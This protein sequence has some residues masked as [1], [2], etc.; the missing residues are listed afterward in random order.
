MSIK[1]NIWKLMVLN[2][3]SWFLLFMPTV[4]LFFQENGLSMFQVILLQSFFAIGV[5]TLEIPSGYFADIYGRKKSVIVGSILSCLGFIGFSLSYNFIG[6]VIAELLLAF[7]VSFLSGADYALMY[8]SLVILKQESKYKILQGRL[9]SV[10]N[11]SESIAALVGGLIAVYGLRYTF[12]AETLITFLA[13]PLAFTLKEP[14]RHIMDL[15]SGH[16]KSLLR[17]V[18][19]ALHDHKEIKWLILYSAL[20]GAMGF[21]MVWFIQPYFNL[22]ELPLK[23]FGIAWAILNFSVGI[24]T[25]FAHNFEETLGKTKSIISLLILLFIAYLLLWWFSSIWAI[26]FILIFYLV[27]GI[28]GPIFLD[29][30]NQLVSSEMRATVLSVKSMMFRLLF[31]IIGP[32]AGWIADMYNLQT[33]LLISGIIFFIPGIVSL[34]F[35]WKH[36]AL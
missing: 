33:A 35:L 6:F 21:N 17:T 12:Y 9:L 31:G 14:K 29:Y 13:I 2:A 36:K 4:V 34:L 8:D 1:S 24:F 28:K 25:L 26:T 10:G 30:V 18:K 32:F 22:V 19:Y 23:Y 5:V 27:R 16:L 11:F 3:I 15:S 20:I 7:G